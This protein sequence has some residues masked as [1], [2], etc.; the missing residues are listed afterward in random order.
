MQEMT[1]E[2][3]QRLKTAKFA[4]DVTIGHPPRNTFMPRNLQLKKKELPA[5]SKPSRPQLVLDSSNL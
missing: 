3:I 4:D 5:G 1:A 2:E